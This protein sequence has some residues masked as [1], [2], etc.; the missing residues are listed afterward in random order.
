MV[1]RGSTLAVVPGD[2]VSYFVQRSTILRRL[3]H[4]TL[5]GRLGT[6]TE[7]SQDPPQSGLQ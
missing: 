5:A 3:L 1:R 6:G 2:D 7:I 4:E